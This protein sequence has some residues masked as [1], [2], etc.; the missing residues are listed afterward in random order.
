MMTVP[1]G[2]SVAVRCKTL[3]GRVDQACGIVFRYRDANNYY[4]VRA[5]ALE[6]NIRLYSVQDG[7]RQEL[8]DWS[9]QVSPNVWHALRA[10]V[11]GDRIQVY[12]DGRRVIDDRDVTFGAPGKVGVWTKADSRTHFDDFV[13]ID[14]SNMP[15]L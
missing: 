5:N 3:A 9:G 14:L 1:T 4:I 12:W 8:A 7:R 6:D 13:V 10:D 2:L 15:T 11:V